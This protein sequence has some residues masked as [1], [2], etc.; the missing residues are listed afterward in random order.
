MQTRPV[1]DICVSA[2]QVGCGPL[3]TSVSASSGTAAT[4]HSQVQ[5]SNIGTSCARRSSRLP[6]AKA[7][8]EISSTAKAPTLKS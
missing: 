3:V 6:I 1:S 8:G 5:R 2:C 4:R 7:T